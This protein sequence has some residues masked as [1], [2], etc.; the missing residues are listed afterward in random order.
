MTSITVNLVKGFTANDF[1]NSVKRT[2]A[3][4][5]NGDTLTASLRLHYLNSEVNGNAESSLVLWRK[6]G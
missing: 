1:T 4:T 2:Y 3:I 5:A 6:A